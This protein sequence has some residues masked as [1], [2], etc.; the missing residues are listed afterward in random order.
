MHA[1]E[2]PFHTVI[3]IRKIECKVILRFTRGKLNR[4]EEKKEG[5]RMGGRSR[6]EGETRIF[7]IDNL[8][9]KLLFFHMPHTQNTLSDHS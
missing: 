1:L 7:L 4:D 5:S 6:R 8:W 3:L 2:K 9:P